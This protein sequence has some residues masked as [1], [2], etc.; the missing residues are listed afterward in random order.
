MAIDRIPTL[1]HWNYFLALEDDLNNLSRFVDFSGNDSTY[2]LEIARLLLGASAEVD[3]VLKQL[4]KRFQPD[5]KASCINS[6][7][8]E[9]ISNCPNFINYGI[10]IPRYGLNLQPW[11]SWLEN[12]PPEWWIAHNKVKH[13]R[14]QY[15]D[16]GTLKNCLNAMGGLFITVLHLYEQEAANGD[17]LQFPKL[18]N[19]EDRFFKGSRMGRFGNSFV[20]KVR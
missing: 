13:H 2:S 14:D 7:Y 4:C 10:Q 9:I 17:L 12:R 19:V 1:G 11:E 6:Y 20:Y 16:R 3:V 18:F 5:S 8:P 15:F